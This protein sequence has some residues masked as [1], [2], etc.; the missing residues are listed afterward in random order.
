VLT[1]GLGLAVRVELEPGVV[2]GIAGP[3]ARPFHL[4]L[5]RLELALQVRNDATKRN[6]AGSMVF[7]EP[8]DRLLVLEQ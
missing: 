4:H 2:Q 8:P 3:V 6:L 7:L 1:C 5:R